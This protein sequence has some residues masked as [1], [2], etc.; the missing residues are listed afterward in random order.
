[1]RRG[2]QIPLDHRAATVRRCGKTLGLFAAACAAVA[3]SA[4]GAQAQPRMLVG[5]LDEP[6]ALYGNPD[7]TYPILK[8][9][10]V[11]VVRVNLYWGA[12]RFAVARWRPVDATDPEGP[13]YDWT[14]YDRAARYAAANGIQLLFTIRGTPR[15]ANGGKPPSYAPKKFSDLQ[16]FAY[17]AAQHFSG[18][19]VDSNSQEVPAVKLWTAWNEPNQP[20]QLAPQYKKVRGKWRMQSA[21]DY[22]KICKAVY[23]GV[24]ATLLSGEKVACGATS[25]RGNDNPRGKRP[26]PTPLSFMAAVKKAGLNEFDAWAH[27]PYA[28]SARETPTT[29]PHAR[30][31]VTLGNLDVMIKQINKLWG[32]KR[33]WLTEYGY[34]TNPPDKLFGVSYKK[35]A[36]YLKQAIA[37]ARKNPRVDMLL[38]FL[39]KDDTRLSGWQSGL[40]TATGKKK[41][42]FAA[43]ARAA[44][45]R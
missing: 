42:A 13:A 20:F 23:T 22:A 25:P 32:K 2:R 11:Q 40:M 6:N 10:R 17:A 1:V 18:Y 3:L 24:H 34:Q 19:T 30:G 31:A 39:L 14:L 35:Q 36:Q 41:P 5:L 33:V 44:L 37:I 45:P 28:G 7:T 15:W 16:N 8:A 12:T 9:L 4:P 26:V 21:I 43:F 38:W 29:K 27:N